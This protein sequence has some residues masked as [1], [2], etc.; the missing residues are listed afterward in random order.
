[1]KAARHR[2]DL[3][4]GPRWR[5]FKL[6]PDTN[7]TVVDLAEERWTAT[8]VMVF[9]RANSGRARPGLHCAS[10]SGDRG[11][12]FHSVTQLTY[13]QLA[14]RCP[15]HW[16]PEL[17]FSMVGPPAPGGSPLFQRALLGHPTMRD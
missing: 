11:R 13:P 9:A 10:P 1:M 17:I 4:D 5:E 16:R 15:A 12:D 6:T 8:A 14:Y 3:G 2:E 7:G